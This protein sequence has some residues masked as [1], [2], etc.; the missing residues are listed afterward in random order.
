MTLHLSQRAQRVRLSPIAAASQHAATLAAQGRDIVALTAGEP[1]F[2]TPDFIKQAAAE[3][4]ARGATKYTA[5]AGTAAL[6]QAVATQLQREHGI[7]VTPAEVFVANGGK[8]VIYEAL[9]ATLDPGDE[10][11]LPTPFW[12]SFPDIV[13]VNDGTPVLL[14]CGEDQRFKLTPAQLEA[15]ITPR[16]RWLVLN[17]PNNPTGAVYSADELVALAAVLRRHP[18]LWVL[19]DEIYDQIR[20]SAERPVHWLQIAPDLRERTLLVNGVSK[21]WAMTGWRIGW[22]I[23][24]VALVQAVIAIQSQVSSGAS[25]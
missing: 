7:A 11:L 14:P 21:T 3:A 1:E 4:L 25:A 2:D 8:Q 24:P 15:A 6:R 20:F 5:T 19:L 13:R 22:G 17:T 12:P 10:V 16:S 18:Q 9:A 23:A